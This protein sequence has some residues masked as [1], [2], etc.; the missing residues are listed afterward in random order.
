MFYT[1]VY[2]LT[3]LGGFGIIILL[4]RKGFEADQ[5]DDYKGLH[6][7]SPWF[8]AM[9]LL[10]MFSMAGVPPTVGFFAKL[11]V[12]E[13]VVS[14]DLV[15]LALVAVF[16]SIIGAFYYIRIVKIMYFDKPEETTPL[17]AEVGLD[18]Q[19]VLTLNGLAMLLLGIFPAGLYALCSA[20]FS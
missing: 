6:E 14:I 2:A 11:F 16:F 5:L 9:M 8:A 12:L 10:F 18:T 1:I 15:W 3:A 13:A 17:P 7:R 20:A 19:V 4:S